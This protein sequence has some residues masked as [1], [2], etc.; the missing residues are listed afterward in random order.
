MGLQSVVT[1]PDV[2]HPD[3]ITL[4]SLC[5]E[6]TALHSSLEHAV[7]SPCCHHLRNVILVV[8]LQY[9]SLLLASIY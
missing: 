1:I 5:Y 7:I 3:L 2:M 8:S 9:R 6:V 4:Y